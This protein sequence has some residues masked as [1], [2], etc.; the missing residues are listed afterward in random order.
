[1][2]CSNLMI[3]LTLDGSNL[4]KLTSRNINAHLL[5]AQAQRDNIQHQQSASLAI[6]QEKLDESERNLKEHGTNTSRLVE[7]M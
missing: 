6:I 3:G 1:M 7:R 2:T 5:G 4:T